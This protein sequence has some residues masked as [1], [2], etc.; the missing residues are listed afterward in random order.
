MDHCRSL[1]HTR[2]FDMRTAD[3]RPTDRLKIRL[4]PLIILT[5]SGCIMSVA[6]IS[7]NLCTVSVVVIW[8]I[9]SCQ[10]R[11]RSLRLNKSLLVL[12]PNFYAKFLLVKMQYILIAIKLNPIAIVILAQQSSVNTTRR[13]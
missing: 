8:V 7:G 6:L 4:R 10:L 9:Q 1:R 2:D 11:T 13:L 3:L 12:V 5:L